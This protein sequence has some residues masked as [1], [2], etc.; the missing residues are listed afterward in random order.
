MALCASPSDPVIVFMKQG[1]GTIDPAVFRALYMAMALTSLV[2][3]FVTI[4]LNSLLTQTLRVTARDADRW[5]ILLKR[6][7]LPT[8]CNTIFTVGNVALAGL[9]SLSMM[10]AFG[11]N[12]SIIFASVSI[13][14]NGFCMHMINFCWLLPLGHPVHGWH[15]YRSEEFDLTEPLKR[16]ERRVAGR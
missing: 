12:F 7:G 2:C 11:L 8:L 14:V 6:D 1:D 13:F 5:R 10:P 4:I 16:L 9:I 3:L 15:K